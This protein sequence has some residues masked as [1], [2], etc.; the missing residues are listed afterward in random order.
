MNLAVDT[1]LKNHPRRLLILFVDVQ[2][3]NSIVGHFSQVEVHCRLF[4]LLTLHLE[5]FQIVDK[6]LVSALDRE[7]LIW[8]R[9]VYRLK[10]FV[11]A[12]I[13]LQWKLVF[14]IVSIDCLLAIPELH[15]WAVIDINYVLLV[16]LNLVNRIWETRHANQIVVRRDQRHAIIVFHA[17]TALVLCFDRGRLA[18]PLH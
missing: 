4:F 12:L 2:A 11:T 13:K 14:A 1:A 18:K 8:R 3:D 7:E 6:K 9:K 10:V 17:E 5:S 16:L 15:R